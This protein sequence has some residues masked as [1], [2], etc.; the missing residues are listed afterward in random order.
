MAETDRMFTS[1]D[2][3]EIPVT[4]ANIKNGSVPWSE[5]D[6][7]ELG[8]GK[9]RDK[10]GQWR[11][12][13]GSLLPRTMV[14]EI[15]RRLKDRY[16]DRLREHLK[17]AQGVFL[18]IMN[19]TAADPKDRLKAAQYMMERLIGKVPDKVEVVAEIKPWE[20]LIE[21]ILTDVPED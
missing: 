5:L 21:G 9:L 11:G 10:N 12:G 1:E 18:D 7:E 17:N 15:T 14:P 16:D 4:W 3:V 20:G 13:T 6:D 19:D 2:G 8:K